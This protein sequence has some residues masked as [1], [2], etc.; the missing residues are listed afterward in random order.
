MLGMFGSPLT[1]IFALSFVN[2]V[3]MVLPRSH[4]AMY[5]PS[6]HLMSELSF[7]TISVCSLSFLKALLVSFA[8]LLISLFVAGEPSC[9]GPSQ[10][11]CP[12]GSL[13]GLT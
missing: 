8:S 7:S 3:L 2:S 1:E 11:Q 4:P 5:V 9:L 13:T 6:R 12:S 10:F